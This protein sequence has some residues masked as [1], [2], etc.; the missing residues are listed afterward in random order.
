[1]RLKIKAIFKI[2]MLA[3]YCAL[4]CAA[5]LFSFKSVF[6]AVTGAN[7]DSDFT[8]NYKSSCIVFASS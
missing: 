2:I 1:M 3:A 6:N 5:I 7:S 8:E 4:I